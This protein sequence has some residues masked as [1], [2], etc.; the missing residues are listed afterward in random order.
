MGWASLTGCRRVSAAARIFA[1]YLKDATRQH[2]GV[3]FT[4]YMTRL[5]RDLTAN[6]H[7]VRDLRAQWKEE[8]LPGGA[9]SQVKRAWRTHSPPSRRRGT[10]Y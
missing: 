6:M 5:T 7:T 8:Y 4:D 10:G 1:D 9:D 2:H 3:A